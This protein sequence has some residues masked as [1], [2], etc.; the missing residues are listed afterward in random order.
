[1]E[2]RLRRGQAV[3]F[4][5]AEDLAGEAA[6]DRRTLARFGTRSLVAVP[7]AVA[8]SP[9]GVLSFA[10]LWA[11]RDWPVEL[12]QRLR[13]L[14][15]ILANAL[16]RRQAEDEVRRKREELAH[17]LRVTTLG[18]LAASLAHEVNQPLA[19]IL[20]NAQ[21]ARRLLAADPMETGELREALVDIADDARHASQVIRRLRA[22]YRKE[23]AEREPVDVNALIAVVWGLM[24]ADIQRRRIAVRILPGSALPPVLGDRVQLQ[25]VILNAL[26]NACDAIEARE[27]G[28]RTIAIEVREGEP[29]E[30]EIATSDSGIGVK[31]NALD[32]IFEPFT[33]TKPDGLGMGLS[34]SR[35][36]VEAH[37]GRIWARANAQ[38]G[39]T[40]FVALPCRETSDGEAPRASA[41][42][43]TE[44][45]SGPARR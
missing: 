32:R 41:P 12:I 1:M 13:L 20:A 8:G 3:S 42:G 17:V 19:A 23:P 22:L 35:S 4:S 2:E 10:T 30:I 43:P 25:Q 33:S 18:E 38:G 5:R 6:T 34:I 44:G 9:V 29:G 45:D 7:L 27:D 14:G 11:E 26:V 24:R 31:E 39:L 21:A 40:L 36:I 15:E 28:P 37:G 16:A